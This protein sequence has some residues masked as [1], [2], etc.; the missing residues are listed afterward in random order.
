MLDLFALSAFF[1]S[2]GLHMTI[3]KFSVYD[4]SYDVT[5]NLRSIHSSY[6]KRLARPPA[7]RRVS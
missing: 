3:G 1:F 5:S 2:S 4:F 6:T 7:L